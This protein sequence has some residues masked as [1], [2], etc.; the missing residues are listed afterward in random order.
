[1]KYLVDFCTSRKDC[2][3]CESWAEVMIIMSRMDRTDTPVWK[4]AERQ[5][6]GTYKLV[7]KRGN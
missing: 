3:Y 6:D 7:W 4:V 5:A 1:M 2:E